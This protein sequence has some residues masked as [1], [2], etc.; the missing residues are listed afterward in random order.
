MALNKL[1]NRQ[2]LYGCLG[3]ALVV[4]LC[5]MPFFAHVDLFSEYRRVLFALE[6][7]HL[8][9]N[10]HRIL[11]YYIEIAFAWLSTWF[12][13]V[14]AALFHLPDPTQSTASL[15]DYRYFLN[16]PYVYRYLFFFKLPYLLFDLATALLI[17]RFIDNPTGKRIAL[18]LWLF[19]PLTIFATYIFGRFEVISLFFLCLT[20]YQLKQ[21]K[22]LLAA[23][24]FGVS[25]W[26]RE[27]NL[28]FLPILLIAVID[29]KDSVL[30]NA[31]IIGICLAI[32]LSLMLL[33]DTL[34]PAL[35]GNLQLF[36]DPATA[37]STESLNKLLSLGYHWFYPVVIG[38]LAVVIYTWES[39]HL[40]HAER[41]VVGSGLMLLVY[42]AFNVHSIQYAAWLMIF[43]VLA[44]SYNSKVVIPFVGLWLA[45]LVLWLLKTDGGV[46]TLFLAAPLSIDFMSM[47]QFPRYFNQHIATPELTLG[48]AIAIMRSV[49]ATV[50]AFLAYRLIVRRAPQ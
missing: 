15:N 3:I 42:F 41:F 33:P 27:I 17:W 9:D 43:P 13:P 20:A 12:I 2:F 30:R 32:I 31:L 4:R 29:P 16:D 37:R 5:I 40:E 21:H 35:G 11:V 38:L 45:W 39:L 24:T 14:E 19:N 8:L 28:L 44:I 46:F 6:H 10:S 47:G 25:L 50:L 48:Q 7:G 18:L 26:C 22:V 1:D 23:L 49:F 36:L 34:L